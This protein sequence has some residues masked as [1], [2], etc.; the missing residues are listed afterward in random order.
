MSG[1]RAER[2]RQAR[3]RAKQ[4]RVADQLV[5]LMATTTKLPVAVMAIVPEATEQWFN[6]ARAT[7]AA[8]LAAKHV[9]LTNG[10]AFM[11][12]G[13]EAID[14]AESLIEMFNEPGWASIPDTL[15]QYPGSALVACFGLAM[16]DPRLN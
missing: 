9:G 15:R 14:A 5:N 8:Q 7:L 10:Q 13:P 12:T 6:D 2:R 11:Y 16:P 3:E 4:Q 1:D